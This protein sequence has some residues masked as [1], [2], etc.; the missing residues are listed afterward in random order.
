MRTASLIQTAVV[1]AAAVFFSGCTTMPHN[2]MQTLRECNASLA[3]ECEA[4]DARI[5]CIEASRREL[6]DRVHQAEDQIAALSNRTNDDGQLLAQQRSEID[7][8]HSN[9]AGLARFGAGVSAATE[10]RLR[11]IAESFPNLRFDP[12]T[13]IAKLDTDIVFESGDARLTPAADAFLRR[14]GGRL[15]EPDAND[16]KVMLVGHTDDRRIAGRPTRQ[17]FADNF[18]LSTERAN[19]VAQ[20]LREIGLPDNRIGVAGFGPH[21]PIA[22]N[23]TSLDRQKNRRVEIFVLA[24]EVPIVGWTESI[25]SVYR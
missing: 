15:S 25:P 21:Q 3:Q 2:R 5:A 20:M 7:D 11:Q 14:L 24:P 17:Q 1:V 23:M 12:E 4:K 19:A 6:V 8:L 22:P 13:G 18:R 16:L 9:Y 10:S